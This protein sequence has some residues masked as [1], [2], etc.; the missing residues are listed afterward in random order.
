MLH[1]KTTALDGILSCIGSLN[2]NH[3]SM[4]VDDEV[5][6][7]ILDDKMTQELKTHFI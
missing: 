7:V 2:F 5:N 4:L 1:G 3:S 6:I